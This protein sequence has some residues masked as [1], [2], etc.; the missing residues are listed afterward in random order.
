MLIAQSVLLT[1]LHGSISIFTE[2]VEVFERA[3]LGNT[4]DPLAK[5]TTILSFALIELRYSFALLRKCLVL[6]L[7]PVRAAGFSQASTAS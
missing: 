7:F 6:F 3:T 1:K 2:D 5:N 4:E